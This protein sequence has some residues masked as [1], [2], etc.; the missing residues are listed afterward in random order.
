MHKMYSRKVTKLFYLSYLETKDFYYNNKKFIYLIYNSIDKQ[1]I[2]MQ[3][4]HDYAS[5]MLSHET[6]CRIARHIGKK[7]SEVL[8]TFPSFIRRRCL[9]EST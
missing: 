4:S 1:Q 5:T 9:Q 6:E 2:L 3:N 7:V 8:G